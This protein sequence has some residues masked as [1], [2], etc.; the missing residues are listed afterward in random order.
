MIE[1]AK[2][3]GTMFGKEDHG[4]FTCNLCIEGAG[5]GCWY[6]GYA[7]DEYDK[8]KNKRVG[9]AVGLSAIIQLLE[10]LEVDEWEELKGQ[11]VRVELTD[12]FGKITKIGHLIKNKWFSF[13]EFFNG[14]KE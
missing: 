11:Y 5:W 7:L 4:I 13:E 1:N 10:T 2:I 12:P 3:T 9:S 6:G 8:D 14:E